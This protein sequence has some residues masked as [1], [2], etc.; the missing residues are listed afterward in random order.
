GTWRGGKA[1]GAGRTWS[2]R[3]WPR[4]R[5][6]PVIWWTFGN[7]TDG[8]VYPRHRHSR[9]PRPG[10]R[11]YRPDHSQAIPQADR[12]DRLRPVSLLRLA[13]EW[14]FHPRSAGVPRRERPGDRC[15]LRMWLVSGARAL[16]AA[17]GGSPG[18]ERPLGR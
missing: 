12:A 14:G 10:E 2:A 5:P 4:R 17:R 7:S 1:A 16:V 8:T 15:E 13:A 11:R 9:P 3:Q 6:S 18:R